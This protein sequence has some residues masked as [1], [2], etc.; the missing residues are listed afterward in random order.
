MT[1]ISSCVTPSF[2]TRP[3]LGANA[4]GVRLA[5]GWRSQPDYHAFV[6]AARALLATI[7]VLATLAACGFMG[8]A[9]VDDPRPVPAGPL[10]PVLPGQG[11]APA[12]ECRGVPLDQCRSFVSQDQQNVVRVIVT[13]TAACTPTQGEVRIDVLL[14]DGSTR[15]AGQGSYATAPEPAVPA[16]EAT[17]QST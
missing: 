16:P 10:G 9:L 2:P 12:V 3:V 17:T 11:G 7:V 14:P 4:H 1:K 8:G 6:H 5:R 13:C 15:Q